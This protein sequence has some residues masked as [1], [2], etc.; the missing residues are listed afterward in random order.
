LPEVEDI[1]AS[2]PEVETDR[3]V[4]IKA[5]PD[6]AV[7]LFAFAGD[8]EATR[9]M[10]WPTNTSF[11]QTENAIRYIMGRY[12]RHEVA[13]WLI[14][15]KA[16]NRVIGMAGFNWWLPHHARAEIS[17]AL[18]R[19]WWGQGLATEA[20]QALVRFGFTEMGCN[21][22]EALVHPENIASRRVAEKVG[23]RQEGLL[24]EVLLLK[25]E[26]ADHLIYG[27]L[28]RDWRP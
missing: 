3:L 10:T 4:L 19:H 2:L 24:R 14:L 22:I 20:V 9:F 15:H 13:P 11:D 7:E 5:S 16:K 28:R 6:R 23:F 1:F 25:G 17:Y 21:R 18:A 12:E 26:P 27:L 8:P